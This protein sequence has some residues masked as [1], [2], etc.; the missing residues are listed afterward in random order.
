M[1]EQSQQ[2]LEGS[3]QMDM[4]ENL[5]DEQQPPED[6][7]AHPHRESTPE[8]QDNSLVPLQ[9]QIHF[10]E[11]NFLLVLRQQMMMLQ[12][13]LKVEIR[14]KLSL[15]KH[16]SSLRRELEA[17]QQRENDLAAKINDFSQNYYYN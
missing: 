12:E 10:S 1:K 8:H 9:Q 3:R 5:L 7:E 11:P 2:E 17:A 14:H 6:T 13:R 15:I 4:I 16:S